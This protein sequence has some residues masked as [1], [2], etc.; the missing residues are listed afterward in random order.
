MVEMM[1]PVAIELEARQTRSQYEATVAAVS[2]LFSK[3]AP[4]VLF[5][6]LQKTEQDVERAQL[7]NRGVDIDEPDVTAA[8]EMLKVLKKWGLKAP[9]QKRRT[10][11]ATKVHGG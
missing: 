6:A 7:L 10:K 11:A 1:L 2:G 8:D 3:E 5:E 4:K 9:K